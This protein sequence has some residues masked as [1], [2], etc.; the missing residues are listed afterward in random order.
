L[1]SPTGLSDLLWDILL[2]TGELVSVV[3]LPEDIFEAYR[4]PFFQ[5]VK[6]EGLPI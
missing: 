1:G 5:N 2:G 6:K 4:D 3:L